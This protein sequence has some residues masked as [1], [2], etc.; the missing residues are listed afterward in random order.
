MDALPA[1]LKTYLG[2]DWLSDGPNLVT[3]NLH[4]LQDGSDRLPD[5]RVT[6]T[7]RWQHVN[8]S[9]SIDGDQ[10]SVV[11]SENYA[12]LV[13][14]FP[15]QIEKRGASYEF[16]VEAS[17]SMRTVMHKTFLHGMRARTLVP[18]LSLI[19]I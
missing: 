9:G 8:M 12:D 15:H 6:R 3:Q 5:L 11:A 18:Y 17:C 1:R 13:A 16:K 19:H 2:C 10:N 4:P 14:R 7:F